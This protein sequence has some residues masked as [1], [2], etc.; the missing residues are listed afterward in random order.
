MVIR[1]LD[2]VRVTA[3]PGEADPPLIIH[4]NTELASALSLELLES[5]RGWDPQGIEL[6]GSSD[7]FEFA[8]GDPLNLLW[9]STRK[10]PLKYPFC[11]TIAERLDHSDIDTNAAR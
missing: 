9:K 4:S 2:V 1:D 7:D 10:L 6:G 8:R 3:A 5:V 11:L